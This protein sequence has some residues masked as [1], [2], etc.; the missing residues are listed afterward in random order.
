MNNELHEALMT[1]V[2]VLNS[3][4]VDDLL[5]RTADVSLDR[6]LFPLLV[7]VGLRGPIGIKALADQVGRDHSTVSR[8]VA[9]L[10]ALGLVRREQSVRD[11]RLNCAAITDEGRHTAEL[12]GK[13]RNRLLDQVLQ[14]WTTNDRV[15]VA[16]LIRRL[17]DGIR[18]FSLRSDG[19]YRPSRSATARI[20][21]T[22]VGR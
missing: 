7:R 6:A 19:R 22:G 20:S 10:E 13:A 17:A 1:L 21:G 11:K 8:Q 12:I 9:R 18:E 15:M 14:G 16:Q 5:L 3:A 2:G 4:Q